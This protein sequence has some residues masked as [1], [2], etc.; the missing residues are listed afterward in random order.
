VKIL[1]TRHQTLGT[2]RRRATWLTKDD[3]V[4]GFALRWRGRW[5]GW[6]ILDN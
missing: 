6:M 3:I 1:H 4:C 5:H 2:F